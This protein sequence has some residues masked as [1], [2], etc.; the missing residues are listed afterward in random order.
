[1]Q[2]IDMDY[3]YYKNRPQ[4][5]TEEFVRGE[6][7]TL[8]RGITA[9]E[10]SDSAGTWIELITDW[11]ALG[12]Y[13][14]GEGNRIGYRTA[15]NMTDPAL[16]DADRYFREQIVP[17]MAQGEHRFVTALLATRH[18]DAI[19]GHYG[20]RFITVLRSQIEPLNPINVDLRIAEGRLVREYSRIG[21]AATLELDG[22]TMTL[23]Q[24]G[25]LVESEDRDLRQKAFQ[26]IREWVGEQSEATGELFGNLVSLRDAMGRNLGFDG[27]VPLGYLGMGRVDYG[28]AEVAAFRKNTCRY[29]TPLARRLREEQAERLGLSQLR[30]WDSGYD[31]ATA[32]PSGKVPVGIQLDGAQ[33]IFDTL[34]P[35]LAEHF[36]TMCR[37]NLIDLENRPG[38]RRGAFCTYMFD[39]QRPAI[40]CNSTGTANDI[41]T[42]IHEVG[43]AF[44]HWESRDIEPIVLHSPT[45]EV[46]EIHS[47]GLEYLTLPFVDEF[48]T[49]EEAARFRRGRWSRSIS[50][51]CYRCT[52][53]EFQH[54]VYENPNVSPADRN[55]AWRQIAERYETGIDYT[56]L[57]D[58]R[59]MRWN[60]LPHIFRSPFY[61]I[62]YA[63]AETAAMQLAMIASEDLDH[64]LEIYLQLCRIGG[65]MG[66]DDI[67][68]ST[69]L[70][71]PFDPELMRD[72]MAYAAREVG[73]EEA[74]V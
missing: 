22:R 11:N 14:R 33:R 2:A 21:A 4:A 59:D 26:A 31:P 46:C 71:S 18:L 55:E 74:T 53:D 64:A 20:S 42:L 28:P 50:A 56:G 49:P 73:L 45:I 69:G 25:N 35:T 23:S 30:P 63:I 44:Q 65:T 7:E 1:M 52:V 17:V 12:G 32:I 6:Y 68:R 38:K 67:F 5:L 57:E 34:S 41:R 39:E 60:L 62:D 27:F 29:A 51:M 3:K 36:R 16:D 66:I 58:Y 8:T 70:R 13:L 54:W 43:H 15:Q 48:F 24:A 61:Y 72:L 47:I 9:A 40:L 19:A 37:E 10:E